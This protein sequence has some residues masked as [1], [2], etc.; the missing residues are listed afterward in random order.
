LLSDAWLAG[1]QTASIVSYEPG[2]NSL[3][4]AA[5]ALGVFDGLHQGHRD[6]IAS[7]LTD[8]R[9]Q[10]LRPVIVSF[11]RDPDELFLPQQAWQ[12]LMSNADRLSWLA[13]CG[14]SQVLALP[15]DATIAKMGSSE[16]LDTVLSAACKPCSIHVGQGFRYGARAA[17]DTSSL[18][19]WAQQHDCQ[20]QV[21]ELLCE[22]GQPLSATRIRAA[23]A[24]GQLAEANSMLG[25]PYYLRAQV[26]PGRRQGRGLGFA[27]ANL[28][29][30][31]G[32]AKLSDGVYGGYVFVGD[33]PYKSAISVGVPVTFAGAAATIE[34]HLLDFDGDLYG[35]EVKAAFVQWL[36]PMQA[37]ASPAELQKAV[38]ANI[39]WVQQ[40]L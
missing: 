2:M 25:R 7:M 12:K 24:A 39:D 30:A 15:F 17:G 22:Q 11:E 38:F 21:H 31:A 8:A 36:R 10:G 13:T 1:N 14:A 32:S 3:G 9:N 20:L 34:A 23:L 28:V 5:C 26:V 27:T 4:P 33:Q 35:C 40:N 6:L 37:F 16:F 29:P 19:Q 18:G